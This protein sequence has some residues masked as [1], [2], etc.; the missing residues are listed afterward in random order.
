MKRTVATDKQ[1]PSLHAFVSEIQAEVEKGY[2][3]I[4]LTG[5]GISVA[6][7]IPPGPALAAY[8]CK[9][10]A[11]IDAEQ[12]EQNS[13]KSFE[14]VGFN[15]TRMSW[16]AIPAFQP[17]TI[18]QIDDTQSTDYMLKLMELAGRMK[19]PTQMVFDSFF[20]FIMRNKKPTN[21][22][23]LIAHLTT[24]LG[25]RIVLTTN[26]DRLQEQAFEDV[27]VRPEVFEIP[28]GGTLP[29]YSTVSEKPAII[30]LH[31]GT[32]ALVA[33][34]EVHQP[35]SVMDLE[36]FQSYFTNG[37]KRLKNHLLILGFS[38]FD[39]RILRMLEAFLDIGTITP[40]GNLKKRKSENKPQGKPIIFW[41]AY[42][43]ADA[44]RIDAIKDEIVARRELKGIKTTINDVDIRRVQH[45]DAGLFLLHLYQSIAFHL[46][47]SS[48]FFPSPDNLPLAPYPAF[49]N[50]IRHK[51]SVSISKKA[52][53]VEFDKKVEN[54]LAKLERM[55][56]NGILYISSKENV[57]GA[58]SVAAGIFHKLYYK[59]YVCLWFDIERQSSFHEILSSI[60]QAV[61]LK[62]RHDAYIH[63][64]PCPTQ[65]ETKKSIEQLI[66]NIMSTLALYEAT[67][68]IFVN[69]RSDA[70]VDR[71]QSQ[72]QTRVNKND[73]IELETNIINVFKN[74][75]KA[76]L[77]LITR[78]AEFAK[79]ITNEQK[80]L[81][82]SDL[83]LF[84]D[85]W[86]KRLQNRR[87]SDRTDP[88][89]SI[90][91]GIS[92]DKS[93]VIDIARKHV[94]A[95]S[96]L[97][98]TVHYSAL[99]SRA[100]FSELDL[101]DNARAEIARECVNRLLE[102]NRLRIKRGGFLW[103]QPQLRE[104]VQEHFRN[105]QSCSP[106]PWDQNLK[107]RYRRSLGD[108]HEKVFL[109]SSD[110]GAALESIRC[111]LSLL[112]E[113][114]ENCKRNRENSQIWKETAYAFGL[115]TQ[116]A[117]L[118][119]E[120]RHVLLNHPNGLLM[121]RRVK[122]LYQRTNELATMP[123][124]S[125]KN[126][127]ASELSSILDELCCERQREESRRNDR[128]KSSEAAEST[129][130]AAAVHA[131]QRGEFL[132]AT[133]K[134]GECLNDIDASLVEESILDKDSSVTSILG[135]L[136]VPNTKWLAP[137]CKSGEV[138]LTQDNLRLGCKCLRRMLQL[139]LMT[140]E[141]A[142]A[143]AWK[144]RRT[145]RPN[146][147]VL[148]T[149]Y[150][151]Y[152]VA[153]ELRRYVV[154]LGHSGFLL[155][156]SSR[157]R[158]LQAQ[159]L[160]LDGR[161]Y[162][163][164]RRLSEAVALLK[165]AGRYHDQGWWA[166]YQLGRCTVMLNLAE[167]AWKQRRADIEQGQSLR[168]SERFLTNAVDS[169]LLGAELVTE[170]RNRDSWLARTVELQLRI[171]LAVQQFDDEKTEDALVCCSRVRR[172]ALAGNLVKSGD[173][174]EIL[175]RERKLA[176]EN[177]VCATKKDSYRR[178]RIRKFAAGLRWA[179]VKPLSKIRRV[180][181]DNEVK[182][183]IEMVFKEA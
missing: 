46:P 85:N 100:F 80:V 82:T 54:G 53:R 136:L 70:T 159:V 11:D 163:A 116:S 101:R 69:T 18:K 97:E 115:F 117:N 64:R 137:M 21:A 71:H 103:M 113:I 92:R 96:L 145:W 177:G 108:W 181:G 134:L 10:I 50:N 141:L 120:A 68:A 127:L 29:A 61:L 34:N 104:S 66:M 84:H 15:C 55:N 27:L 56:N 154:T 76:K 4:P 42:N 153:R 138:A 49:D 118:L 95:I 147:K 144:N 16:P 174:D 171:A 93:D 139:Q 31:G 121:H 77:C 178:A 65:N 45:Y 156:E 146:S 48:V 58:I 150:N 13:K 25:S 119:R 74:R 148:K 35:P 19:L 111:R 3:L 47:S 165:F 155:R 106:V 151:I 88:W 133:E 180:V 169:F 158:I 52:S 86:A 51:T 130:Y 168:Q 62:L 89:E 109:V 102:T 6:A 142:Q 175:I 41:L 83:A 32:T 143:R 172:V 12:T 149:A 126:D 157:I 183:F 30:K 40:A 131:L 44:E 26:F 78:N 59:N 63:A 7:G 28:S 124:S 112:E 128:A 33:G 22:H 105:T 87:I 23:T 38:G 90:A 162:E 72:S 135:K 182:D 39:T 123:Q 94:H 81:I 170:H 91:K 20:T 176:L 2:G 79:T 122:A 152:N 125:A 57:S 1:P 37:S 179:D 9:L 17:S 129:K 160:S 110:P 36:S 73:F 164:R 98:G 99:V 132:E 114:E 8:I 161:V 24:Y 107:T 167:H 43:A 75:S 60:Y 67:F 14:N 140:L 173:V 5:A 166:E